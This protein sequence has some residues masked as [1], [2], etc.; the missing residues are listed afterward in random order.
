[1]RHATMTDARSS[2]FT[3]EIEQ[4]RQQTAAEEERKLAEA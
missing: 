4:A 2:A 1:M 3:T